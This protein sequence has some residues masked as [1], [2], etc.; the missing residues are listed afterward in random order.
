MKIFLISLTLLYIAVH[1]YFYLIQDSKIFKPQYIENEEFELPKNTKEISLKIS[2]EIKLSGV[3]KKATKPS[4]QLIIYFGGN[5]DDAT[6]F[7]LHVKDLE[8]FDII[9]FNYRGFVKSSGRP[10]QKALFED[11]LRIYDKFA[12]GKK[13]IV[14]GRSLGTGVATYL[15]SKRAVKNIVLITPYDSIENL[16]K[17]NYPYLFVS[18][19]LKH[20][21]N[22]LK[23]IKDLNTP[24]S[25]IEVVND[26]TIPKQSLDNLTNNIKNLALHVKLKDTTHGDV[27]NHPD[28]EKILKEA[29]YKGADK[30]VK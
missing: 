17:R 3:Y 23:Y 13:V 4:T 26:K 5:S 29:I 19:I 22:S 21:F 7:L 10:S 16:S 6:K 15:A 1:L 14:I 12:K 18:V 9:A 30:D 20:K 27:L 28:F 2:N 8:D 25:I 11:A 24:V